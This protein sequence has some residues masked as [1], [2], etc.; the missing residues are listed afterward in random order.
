M[1]DLRPIWFHPIQLKVAMT[2]RLL[3]ACA[4]AGLGLVAAPLSAQTLKYPETKKDDVVEDYHGTRVADPYRW[5]EDQNGARTAE[6]V[7]AQNGVTYPY[8]NALPE[9]EGIRKRLTE[10]WNYER[11]S[12]P[13]KEGGQYFYYRNSG[14]Q[15]QSVLYVQ[16]TLKDSARVLLDPNTLSTDGT[17]ALASIAISSDGKL[18]G[19]GTA[20]SG[21]DWNEFHVRD[22]ATGKDLGDHIKW[23]KFS[24]MSWL[25]NNRGFL[26][27]RYPE[28]KDDEKLKAALANQMLYYHEVGTD[29][30]KDR[31]IYARPDKPDWFV[32]GDVTED[33]RYLLIYISE[34]T[35]PTNR[36]YYIDLKNPAQPD[37]SGEVVK[38]IDN[39]DAGYNVIGND[40]PVF[41]VVTNHNAPRQKI[42]AIDTR[43]P[44][45]A[46]W[47]TLVPE[48]E[49]VLQFA[50]MAGDQIVASYLKD[51]HSQLRVF[52]TAGNV[53]TQIA[54]S[55]MGTVGSLNGK[56]GSNELFYTFTSFLFPTTVFRY[57]MDTRRNDVFRRPDVK[58]DPNAFETKQVFYTS[59]D[60]TRVPMF[61]THKKGITLDGSNPTYLYGYGGFNIS[62]TPTF[63]V[64][65]VVWMEKGG[66][67]AVANLRGGGEYG[68]KWH[69]AGTKERK[70]NVF[71]DFIAAAEYLTKEGYTSPAKLAIGGG[72]NG[73]LLVGAAMTQRPDL[74]AVAL[75]DVG[76]LDMLRYH[77]FTVGWAWA[78]D[79][80]SS[81]DPAAFKYL[82]AYSPL[83]NIKPGVCY[84]ATMIAT[85]DHDD[86]VVPGHSFK[87]AAALQAA[88]SCE[89]PALIRI[90]S[91][92]GHG[93]GT[94]ISKTIEQVADKWAFARYNMGIRPIVQ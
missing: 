85:A 10:L 39:N 30:S 21:S 5:L 27:S 61:I 20:T 18:M 86:R 94:P 67:Y 16:K 19:Y 28:P 4:C 2:S 55:T 56:R 12:A 37:L 47:T 38:L 17:V 90:E 6:W 9:R 74:F 75:P 44:E 93:A 40:G 77:K 49:D 48:S 24:G 70:Q 82:S 66:V 91:K 69:K 26:Y 63:S 78:S 58:F 71:D 89:K 53:L 23:A 25:R 14:L 8:L 3:C 51:A 57:E 1:Y 84:P 35:N 29:Q 60:G 73:G 88:Q 45:P 32:G 79:Y 11:F 68:D 64:P 92:A 46:N 42:I 62:I 43:K 33:G 50:T 80:G 31:L 83:H 22:V 15:N 87:Y 81:D 76:V 13:F 59:K 72:S 54:L 41:Y 7:Q 36:L 52:S 34:N 65:N